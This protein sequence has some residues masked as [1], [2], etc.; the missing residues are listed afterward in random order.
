MEFRDFC[1]IFVRQWKLFFSVLSGFIF[2]S[3]V[4]FLFQPS[5]F[6]TSLTLN[7]SRSGTRT[8]SDYAY[9]QFYRLQADERFADTVVRWLAAPSV[10]SDIRST[11]VVSQSVADS[12]VAKRLSSQ[13]IAVTYFSRDRAG[14]GDMAR[15]VPDM[16]NAETAKLNALSNDTDW[17]VVMSDAPVLRDARISAKIMIPFGAA[18]GMFF[19]FWAVL[20]VWYFQGKKT[21]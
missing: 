2:L 7:V 12:I 16:L 8:T 1:M 19:G 13:M 21:D 4:A 6:E 20:L 10:R 17:F 3:L 11:A 5:R 14:F 18:L 9:D 15:A